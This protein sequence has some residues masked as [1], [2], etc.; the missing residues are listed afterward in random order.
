LIVAGILIYFEDADVDIWS[1]RKLDAWNYAMKTAGDVN[2]MIVVN[3][4]SMDVSSPDFDLDFRVVKELPPL[5]NAIYLMGPNELEPDTEMLWT[6]DHNVDWYCFG[7]AAGWERDE[8]KFVLG[9]S[10]HIPQSGKAAQHSVHV[11]PVVMMHRFAVRG[12]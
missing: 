9:R 3:R 2:S 8:G 7:P 10:L 4:T 6:F 5:E 1:G 11:A 12:S